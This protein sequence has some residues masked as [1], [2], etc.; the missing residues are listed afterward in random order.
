MRSISMHN[1]HVASENRRFSSLARAME[2]L[3][4]SSCAIIPGSDCVEPDHANQK[5]LRMLTQTV[6]S[7][8]GELPSNQYDFIYAI[9]VLGASG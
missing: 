5:R 9:N 7:D 2:F 6:V 3:L 8:I 4:K 1:L